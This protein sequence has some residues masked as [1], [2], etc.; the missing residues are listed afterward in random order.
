VLHGDRTFGRSLEQDVPRRKAKQRI[1]DGDVSSM[2]SDTRF[3]LFIYE[4]FVA[5]LA[6]KSFMHT[7]REKKDHEVQLPYVPEGRSY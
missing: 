4:S 7:A 3:I 2:L 5:C 6:K 1:K